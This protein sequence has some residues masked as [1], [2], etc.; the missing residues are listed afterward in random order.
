MNFETMTLNDFAELL[1][2]KNAV[3]GGGVASACAGVLAACLAAMVGNLT[4]GKKKYSD[5]EEEMKQLIIRAEKSRERLF[6]LAN[7]DAVAFAP[8]AQ[9]YG[10]P[11]STDEERKAKDKLMEE[12]LLI[13]S[14]APLKI[15]ETCC[16]VLDVLG[17]I[18]E[19][20][21]RIAISDAGVGALFAGAALKG[22]Y[23]NVLINTDSLKDRENADAIN[24]KAV[25]MIARYAPEAER[26]YEKIAGELKG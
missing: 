17:E 24:C 26:I 10:L 2:S 9:A 15:M 6:D 14:R 21:S 3:P 1:S 13:A 22:A 4:V 23:L 20:G 7:E 8:L 11:K 19:K 18:A 5:V 12:A 16:E 25:D